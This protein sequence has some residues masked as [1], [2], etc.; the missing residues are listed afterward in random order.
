MV[1]EVIKFSDTFYFS[2]WKQNSSSIQPPAIRSWR[3]GGH[4]DDCILLEPLQDDKTLWWIPAFFS[5]NHKAMHELV[6]SYSKINPIYKF[7]NV[8]EGKEHID[9][10]LTKLSKLAIFL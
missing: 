7:T 2:P 4:R 1:Q 5:S 9:M 3:K 10:L 8:D 6:R